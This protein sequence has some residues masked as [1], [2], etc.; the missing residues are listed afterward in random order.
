MTG[1]ELVRRAVCFEGPERI[2]HGLPSRWKNDFFSVG[3]GAD[4]DWK[5]KVEGEDEWGCV[6]EKDAEGRTMGQVV[7]HPLKDYAMLDD[8]PFP[9]YNKPARYER[10]KKSIPDNTEDKFV[11][12]GI[13][14]SLIHRLEYL[15]GHVEAWTDPY[16]HP[17]EL[18]ALLDGLADLAIDAVR[19]M[20]DIGAQGIISCDDWG[21]QDRP[22]VSPD[23]FREFFK[24]RYARVYGYARERGLLTFLHSCGHIADLLD[25]FIETDLQVIQMDQQ[26][27]MGVDNLAKRFGGRLCFW[28]P[29]DIQ[30]TM[31][32]GSLDD[33]RAYAR[34]LIEAFGA[35]NGG[36]IS[37][38]YPSPEGA[39][40]TEE[41]ID[42]MC[43]A[44]IEYG[45]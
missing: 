29:V 32:R 39:G 41:K 43:E 24:P 19:I 4:P 18:G 20:A 44:F 3:V 6:W 14:F 7:G 26:E 5:P 21:L 25:D 27:N 2:P 13:P 33:I 16:E 15:R 11:L 37:K 40:H 17:A 36:F 9:D 31:V 45:G 38:W 10:A 1:R 30:Q 23:I 8:F 42:A 22:M 35:F 28:C 34:H 12:A